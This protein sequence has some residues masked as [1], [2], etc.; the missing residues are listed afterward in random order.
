MKK[1]LFI[2]LV[3]FFTFSFLPS[4]KQVFA[5]KEL[6][7]TKR[8]TSIL[9]TGERLNYKIKC[10]D[11][12]TAKMS[13]QTDKITK[14]DKAFFK[15]QLNLFTIGLIRDIFQMN[16]SYTAFVDTNLELPTLVENNISQAGKSQ[17]TTITYD[18]KNHIVKISDQK[19]IAILPQTHDISSLLWAIRSASFKSNGEKIT[20]FNGLNQQISF[21]QLE[22]A[23]TQEIESLAMGKILARELVVKLQDKDKTFSDKYAIRIWLTDDERRIPLLITAQASFGKIR[24]ELLANEENSEENPN[25]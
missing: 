9:Q 16:N 24:I 11:I 17:Q 14:E 20:F 3:L 5:N 7:E 23:T 6:E 18:Q 15:L 13:L 1:I 4:S 25:Q 10:N 22:L 12:A 2:F 8:A 21:L 19:P